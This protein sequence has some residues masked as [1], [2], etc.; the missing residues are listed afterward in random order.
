LKSTQR[1]KSPPRLKL[2]WCSTND[3]D[4]DWFV[5]ARSSAEAA[6]FFEIQ[7][8]YDRQHVRAEL[9]IALPA[10]LQQ[11]KERG[12]PTRELL[13]ACGAVIRR[14]EEPRVVEIGG[15]RYVEGM[16]EHVI[17]QLTDDRF[18]ERGRGRP[19]R[20]RRGRVS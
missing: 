11:T 17:L 2:Y 20:T 14:W 16:L 13:E 1:P 6:R 8:G 4:E 12:W 15:V 10:D 19:N 9:S 18:E 3:H 5:V 7:E